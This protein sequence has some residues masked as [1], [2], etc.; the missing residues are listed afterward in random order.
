MSKHSA[1]DSF[2]ARTISAVS[3]GNVHATYGAKSLK[4]LNFWVPGPKTAALYVKW[5]KENGGRVTVDHSDKIA[6]P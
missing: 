4:A 2:L 6:A 5:V 1:N 3:S